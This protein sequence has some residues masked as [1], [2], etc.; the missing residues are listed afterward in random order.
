M[1]C[2]WNRCRKAVRFCFFADSPEG[3]PKFF[4][5]KEFLF[6]PFSDML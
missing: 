6:S 5:Q 2:D 1:G 3:S 4:P